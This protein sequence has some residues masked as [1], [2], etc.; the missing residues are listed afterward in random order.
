M[1]KK[2]SRLKT[3]AK[4]LSDQDLV[5][6][7]QMRNQQRADN[8]STASHVEPAASAEAPVTLGSSSASGAVPPPAKTKKKALVSISDDIPE[9]EPG[10]READDRS[11]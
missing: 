5:H 9:L 6:V 1:E 11:E 10:A 2:R 7:L 8:A 4:L 3:R